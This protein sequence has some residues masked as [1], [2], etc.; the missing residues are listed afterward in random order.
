MLHTVQDYK[1]Y[2]SYRVGYSILLC[3]LYFVL[4]CIVHRT[5]QFTVHGIQGST[6]PVVCQ[7]LYIIFELQRRVMEGQK[8]RL[9]VNQHTHRS[10]HVACGVEQRYACGVY[11]N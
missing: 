7:Y 11:P 9:H 2:A 10:V 1:T 5:V 6:P 3:T 8:R 4:P